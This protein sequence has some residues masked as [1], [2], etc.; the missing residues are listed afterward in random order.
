M[1][2]LIFLSSFLYKLYKYK[3]AIKTKL[4]LNKYTKD[5]NVWWYIRYDD[6][7]TPNI[8]SVTI[9]S[10][11]I[12]LYN[13]PTAKYNNKRPLKIIPIDNDKPI[14]KLVKISIK[15]ENNKYND[16]T[17]YELLYSFFIFYHLVKLYH[18]FI[19]FYLNIL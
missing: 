5:L 9:F 14:V 11:D 4:Y 18:I 12:Y 15:K 3:N 8:K 1:L 7:N 2:R 16:I 6:E 13:I 19:I 17:R 10:L